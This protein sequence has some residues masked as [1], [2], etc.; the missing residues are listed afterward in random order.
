M[1]SKTILLVLDSLQ[2]QDNSN[3]LVPAIEL[4]KEHMVKLPVIVYNHHDKPKS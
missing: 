3:K 1:L 2:H 4:K